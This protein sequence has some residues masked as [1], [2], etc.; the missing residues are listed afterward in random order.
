M[1]TLLTIATSLRAGRPHPTVVLNALI[2]TENAGGTAA[3]RDLEERLARL[4]RIMRERGDTRRP[5]ARVWLDA[6]R[7]YLE[8]HA[9][10]APLER[11]PARLGLALAL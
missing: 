2:E 5:T 11:R 7:A 8:R 1:R 4:E 6:T 9:P 3:L 10:V